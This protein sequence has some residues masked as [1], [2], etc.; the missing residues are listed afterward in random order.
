[1][2]ERY[3]LSQ[4]TADTA[5]MIRWPL[6]TLRIHFTGRE[7]LYKEEEYRFQ[8]GPIAQRLDSS[9][10]EARGGVYGFLRLQIIL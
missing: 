5:D 3:R 1:M 9:M 6:I 7:R 10:Q 2:C 4:A 8:F